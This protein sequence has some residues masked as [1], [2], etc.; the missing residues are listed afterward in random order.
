M[1]QSDQSICSL[2]SWLLC[3]SGR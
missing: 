2:S 3:F 1:N